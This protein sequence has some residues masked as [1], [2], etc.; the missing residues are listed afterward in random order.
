MEEGIILRN[1]LLRRMYLLFKWNFRKIQ[2]LM[3]VV[4]PKKFSKRLKMLKKKTTENL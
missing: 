1:K 3:R 4:A 2:V